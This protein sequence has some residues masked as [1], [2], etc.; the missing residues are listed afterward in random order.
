MC[1][2]FTLT[3]R[4]QHLV[5]QFDLPAIPPL[6]PRYNIAPTQLVAAV[7]ATQDGAGR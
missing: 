6:E 5:V 2:R 4:D 1:G 3:S 7:R